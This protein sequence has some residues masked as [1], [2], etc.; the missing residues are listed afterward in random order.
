MIE[1]N[2]AHGDGFVTGIINPQEDGSALVEVG[3]D[4][5]TEGFT[6]ESLRIIS[7]VEN[8]K[9]MTLAEIQLEGMN[10]ACAILQ[11]AGRALSDQ[12]HVDPEA[13]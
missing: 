13:R 10:R 2:H 3:A 9:G 12:I 4:V 1:F 8:A 11:A 7:R 5:K 6:E